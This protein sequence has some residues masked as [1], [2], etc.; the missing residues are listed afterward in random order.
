MDVLEVGMATIAVPWN[1]IPCHHEWGGDIAGD[2]DSTVNELPRSKQAGSA[3][4]VQ[5][6][7]VQCDDPGL[8][9]LR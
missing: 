1:W 5:A 7:P 4:N 2:R 8:S 3:T 6:Y 9:E